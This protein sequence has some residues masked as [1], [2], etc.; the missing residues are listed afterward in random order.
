MRFLISRLSALGDVVCTLPVASAL[1]TQWPEC[2]ISWIVDRRFK[3][4]VECCT[5]VDQVV[6]RPKSLAEIK[7]LGE[8]DVAFDMQ[9]LFK[10][11]VLIGASR[12]K[13]KLGYHWQREFSG[14]FSQ[15]VLPDKSSL[16]IVDQYLDVA[17][18]AGA[19][20][21]IAEFRLIPK[22][23]D[24]Q[25]VMNQLVEKG[26]S[27]NDLIL[28]NAGA[29]WITKRWNPQ[30]YA[31]VIQKAN[32]AGY[33]IA[34]L[35]GP[36]DMPAYEEISA[37]SN[38]NSICMV[39]ATSIRELVALVSLATVV[40]GGDTGST[41]ISAAIGRPT[42]GIYTITNPVR[43]CPYGQIDNCF[44]GDPSTEQVWEKI[45]QFIT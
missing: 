18:A 20:T 30:K 32:D 26:W 5:A 28:C 1:K 27:S 19:E 16:H 24:V 40:V 41:H 44:T 29:G 34:F 35:G 7:N 22:P 14:L 42:V 15:R 8:F 37:L 43:S 17:R 36:G 31:E 11:G 23:E 33:P 25:K 9:G 12:A 6:D 3:G 39:G 13:Q 45:L 4:I 2:E 10:S 21:D 38:R